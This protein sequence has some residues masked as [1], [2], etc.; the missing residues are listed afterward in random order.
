MAGHWS[1]TELDCTRT[2]SILRNT[3][4]TTFSGQYLKL[5]SGSC[6]YTAAQLKGAAKKFQLIL[7]NDAAKEHSHTLHGRLI[8]EGK[9]IHCII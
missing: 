8:I 1:C 5:D 7:S 9:T 2:C 6:E 4:Y 3:H